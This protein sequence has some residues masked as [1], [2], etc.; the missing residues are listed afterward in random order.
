MYIVVPY[1]SYFLYLIVTPE[2]PD[3]NVK[4]NEAYG[5]SGGVGQSEVM[6]YEY[7][8]VVIHEAHGA[9]TYANFEMRPIQGN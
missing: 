1:S 4:S 3:M 7:S 2:E 6:D 5:V 9:E 8:T